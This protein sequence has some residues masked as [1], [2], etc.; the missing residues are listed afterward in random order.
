[1]SFPRHWEIFPSEGGASLAAN[2]PAHR[3]DEFPAGY[4]WAGCSPAWARLR[5][6]SRASVCSNVVLPVERFSS[7]GQLC[8][9]CLCHPRGQAHAHV[10][11][12]EGVLNGRVITVTFGGHDYLKPIYPGY[13]L[14]KENFYQT[15]LDAGNLL[16]RLI[17]NKRESFG[18]RILGDLSRR[19]SVTQDFTI[20]ADR[21]FR[22][23]FARQSN[24]RRALS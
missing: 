2:A 4:S 16:L 24:A 11:S 6:T 21:G 23:D 14:I 20:M 5:F 12:P 18:K 9:N 13:S 10:D 19:S 17:E 22:E 3:L 15:G 1:M 7:N 8:L